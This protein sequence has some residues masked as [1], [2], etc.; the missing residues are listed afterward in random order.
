MVRLATS[1]P[2]GGMKCRGPLVGDLAGGLRDRFSLGAAG[3]HEGIIEQGVAGS[4]SRG[5]LAQAWSS[6]AMD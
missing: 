5:M 2:K 1:S 4:S 3:G 6:K